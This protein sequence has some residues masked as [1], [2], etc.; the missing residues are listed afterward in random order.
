MR[1]SQRA[2]WAIPGRLPRGFAAL[3]VAALAL[4]AWPAVAAAAQ[5]PLLDEPFTGGAAAGM[6]WVTGGTSGRLSQPETILPCLTASTATQPLVNGCP[7]GQVAIRSGGDAP[8]TGTLRLTDNQTFEAAFALDREPRPFNVALS[9]DFDFFMYDNA[10]LINAPGDGIAFFLADGSAAIDA[11]GAEGGGLGYAPIGGIKGLAGG[12]MGVGFDQLGNFEQSLTDGSG[13]TPPP[14]AGVFPQP[15]VGI[16][17]PGS[18]TTGYCLEAN[19]GVL[20]AALGAPRATSRSAAGVRRHAHIDIDNP[21]APSPRVTVSIDF[22]AGLVPVLTGPLPSDPPATFQFGFSGG[23]G[24]DDS[25]HE[26]SNVHVSAV[27]GS[28]VLTLQKTHQ[29]SFKP[30]GT[31]VFT[32]TPAFSSSGAPESQP[33]TVID[34]LPGGLVVGAIPTGSGWDCSATAVGTTTASCTN[35]SS[36]G[37]SIA[38]GTTLP[39]ITLSVDVAQSATGSLFNMATV[40]SADATA[41]VRAS[42]TA[43]IDSGGRLV[44]I[45][46]ALAAVFVA[47]L[48]LIAYR[49]RRRRRREAVAP[50]AW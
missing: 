35:K 2:G 7:P 40:Y 29:G 28:T 47:G 13:C 12:Y 37:A 45:L 31:G 4:V 24:V 1:S 23:T 33:V 5:V 26:V 39:A 3:A 34:H 44:P 25:V 15:R 49:R 41:S 27:V 20:P 50:R 9:V 8:G 32:L 18:G 21:A 42:D 30:G 14:P 38:P 10:S 17:G 46:I 22:G 48:L 36:A 11:P 6:H 16:R 19:S 43:K